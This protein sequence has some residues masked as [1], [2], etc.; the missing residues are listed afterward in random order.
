MAPHFESL[1][2]S[3]YIKATDLT[4]MGHNVTIASI[5][6]ET[7]KGFDDEPDKDL[8]VLHFN[9]TDKGM[10][11]NKTNA[12]A[13]SQIAGVDYTQWPGAQ[14]NIFQDTTLF[15]GKTVQCVRIRAPQVK[16]GAAKATPPPTPPVATDAAWEDEPGG[17]DLDLPF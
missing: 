9:G 4:P 7:I 1:F 15:K 2:P 17:D 12:H 3:T 8:P 16:T 14:I 11:C 13:V 5:A 6:V 10:T